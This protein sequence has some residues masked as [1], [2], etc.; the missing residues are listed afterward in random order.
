MTLFCYE[1]SLGKS[2][3]SEAISIYQEMRL[4]LKFKMAL[5]HLELN[6]LWGLDFNLNLHMKLESGYLMIVI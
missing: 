4:D 2:I 5:H 3:L 6:K 1:R